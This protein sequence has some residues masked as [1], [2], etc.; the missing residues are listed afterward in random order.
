MGNNKNSH[1]DLQYKHLKVNNKALLITLIAL[2]ILIFVYKISFDSYHEKLLFEEK[3]ETY[4]DLTVKSNL[5]SKAIDERFALIFGLEAYVK[6]EL[7]LGDNF[8]NYN[9]FASGIYNA[10]D[11]IRN[12]NIAPNGITGF[13]YPFE[14]NNTLIGRSLINDDRPEVRKDVEK[15]ITSQ[16]P[17]ISGPYELR[18]GGQG[19]VLR[20]A[21]YN[22][23]KFW[24]L[25]TIAVDMKPIYRSTGL[26]SNFNQFD[27]ALQK[28]GEVFYGQKKMLKDKPVVYKLKLYDNLFEFGAVPKAGW[29]NSIKVKLRL[30][31]FVALII[32]VLLLIIIYM[33]FYRNYKI[34]EIVKSKT[35]E[36]SRAKEDAEAANIAKSRFLA[37]MSHE[38]RTP[39]NG[40]MGTI[41]LMQMTE[42]TE[43][44]KDYI[45][46][47]QTSS[48]A[49]LVVIN[50]ILDYSKIEAGMMKLERIKFSLVRLIEDAISLFKLSAEEKGLVIETFTEDLT[51]YDF[52]GDPFRLR[53]ILSNLIGNAVKFTN[54][55]SI[56]IYINLKE[57][58]DNNKVKLEFII[59]DTGIGIS[60]DKIDILFSSFSQVDSSIT[61]R[62][63]GTGLGLAISKELVEMLSGEIWVESKES[64]GSTFHFTC[65]LEINDIENRNN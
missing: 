48:E 36:L 27:Y 24:G 42:L 18:Q 1:E 34:K 33:A 9:T 35:S 58:H 32:M 64:Q 4:N 21:V 28:N 46:I 5:F 38:I 44:Q 16:K 22:H 23:K 30:F 41:Q 45:T 49:L 11:G 51:K 65:I 26:Y 37:N 55:G 31:K 25:V 52:I 7:I 54:K 19:I 29:E 39:L 2:L 10:V 14:V 20:K 40:I 6:S 47:T 3:R 53:Q 57:K 56:K 61:R 59:K 43:E 62:Y 17:V 13:V 8:S 50:D 63:G 15:T 60:Q 12:L